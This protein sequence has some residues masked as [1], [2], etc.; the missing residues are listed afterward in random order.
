MDDKS[1]LTEE[2]SRLESEKASQEDALLTLQEMVHRIL[3]ENQSAEEFEREIGRLHALIA[4]LEDK[5]QQHIVSL[6]SLQ[7]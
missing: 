6:S 7:V 2:I 1:H 4:D 3:R 5:N